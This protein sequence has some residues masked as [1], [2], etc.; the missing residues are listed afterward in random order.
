MTANPTRQTPTQATNADPVTGIGHGSRSGFAVKTRPAAATARP[1][2]RRRTADRPLTLPPVADTLTIAA[3][4][5]TLSSTTLFGLLM[6][7]NATAWWTVPAWVAISVSAGTLPALFGLAIGSG[8]VAERIEDRREARHRLANPD[9]PA[10]TVE[11][12]VLACVADAIERDPDTID[13][14]DSL[15]DDLEANSLDLCALVVEL[16]LEF[17]ANLDDVTVFEWK[18]VRDVVKAPALNPDRV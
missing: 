9:D 10:Y 3:V 13:L 15:R 4:V 18:T 12:R 14:D 16:E 11:S 5:W 1:T 6:I 17:G 8:I 2:R 7:G